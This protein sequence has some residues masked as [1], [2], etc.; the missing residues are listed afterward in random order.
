MHIDWLF[1]YVS[2]VPA[3]V[4]ALLGYLT[5]TMCSYMIFYTG[6]LIK[7]IKH[8]GLRFLS[9]LSVRY[10]LMLAC[11]LRSLQLAMTLLFMRCSRRCVYTVVMIFCM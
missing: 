1:G 8:L 7:V 9:K 2:S 11:L 4:N 10:L 5:C 6:W 3:W